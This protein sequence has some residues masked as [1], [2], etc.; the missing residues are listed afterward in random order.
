MVSESERVV[1]VVSVVRGGVRVKGVVSV[2]KG[3]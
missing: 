2:R 1:R 3:N